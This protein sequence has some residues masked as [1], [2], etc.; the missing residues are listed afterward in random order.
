[1][2]TFRSGNF[3]SFGSLTAFLKQKGW[4]QNSIDVMT[5][6]RGNA[7]ATI[8]GSSIKGYYAEYSKRVN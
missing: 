7:K 6:F 2:S 4:T 1:M 3:K 5:Y 8:R